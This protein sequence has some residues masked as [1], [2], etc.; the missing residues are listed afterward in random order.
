VETETGFL[1]EIQAVS[2][3]LNSDLS[4]IQAAQAA[5]VELDP[6]ADDYSAQ[7]AQYSKQ[8]A[9]LSNDLSIQQGRLLGLAIRVQSADI[10]SQNPDLA[11]SREELL[12]ELKLLASGATIRSNDLRPT[13]V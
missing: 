13:S 9:A 3:T 1:G 8:I 4:K 2:A 10:T 6:S 11:A 12:S 7:V 5:I